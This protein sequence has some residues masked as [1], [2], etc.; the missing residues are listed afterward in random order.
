MASSCVLRATGDNFQSSAFL[1]DSN[2]EPCNI[3]RKDERKSASNVWDTSG[4]TVVVSSKDEFSAQVRDAIVFLETNR[5][6][7]LRLKQ[8]AGLEEFT[9]DFGV[10][11]KGSFLQCY[12][13]PL[14]LINLAGEFALELEV[15]IYAAE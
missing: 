14:E 8:F 11:E 9:L 5:V 10:N 6:E 2:F 1:R 7:M 4:I 15:S 12:V 13:F 3:F